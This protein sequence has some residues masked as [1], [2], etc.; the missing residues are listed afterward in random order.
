MHRHPHVAGIG[1]AV[2]LGEV[3][4]FISHMHS[5]KRA[6]QEIM[7]S[8]GQFLNGRLGHEDTR[9]RWKSFGLSR[10]FMQRRV[11][12]NELL[13]SMSPDLHGETLM[14]TAILIV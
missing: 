7:D 9:C 3:C 14:C 8:L 12:H 2:I 5:E 1:W 11:R 10:R 13:N 6:L 4:G